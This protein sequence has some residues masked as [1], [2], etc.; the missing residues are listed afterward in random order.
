MAWFTSAVVATGNQ[1]YS[2]L[3]GLPNNIL[4]LKTEATAS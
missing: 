4:I 2:L 3:L 1:I